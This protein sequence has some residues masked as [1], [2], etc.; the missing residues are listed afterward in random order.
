MSATRSSEDSST[1][2]R[3]GALVLLAAAFGASRLIGA[4]H[5]SHVC[6]EG[7]YLE[8]QC[9]DET[10]GYAPCDEAAEGF[11]ECKCDG[12]PGLDVP[13]LASPDAP[14]EPPTSAPSSTR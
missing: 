4:C 3:I 13:G 12:T 14:R 1:K 5:P 8:C 10:W 6:L 11:S 9:D 7:D 2:F